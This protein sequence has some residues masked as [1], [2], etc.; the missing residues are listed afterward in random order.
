MNA[1]NVNG[2]FNAF[3][4]PRHETKCDLLWIF[5]VSSILLPFISTALSRTSL[6]LCICSGSG[7]AVDLGNTTAT[8]INLR[9]D[10]R[11]SPSLS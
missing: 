1:A 3:A 9:L 8:V 2:E 7:G 4:K 6:D 11:N 5:I 10:G